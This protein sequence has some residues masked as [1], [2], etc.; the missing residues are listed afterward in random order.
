MEWLG[1]KIGPGPVSV[2]QSAVFL[3]SGQVRGLAGQ[4]SLLHR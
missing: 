4:N 1:C 3:P 2:N